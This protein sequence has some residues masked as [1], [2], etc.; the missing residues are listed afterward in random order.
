METKLK[1]KDHDTID[2]LLSIVDHGK[3]STTLDISNDDISFVSS[4]S[5]ITE[6]KKI[7]D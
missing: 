4:S 3:P 6:I 7:I 1:L 2:N 5:F